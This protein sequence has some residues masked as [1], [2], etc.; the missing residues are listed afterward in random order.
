MDLGRDLKTARDRL[1]QLHTDNNVTKDQL[2][3]AKR[4][5]AHAKGRLIKFQR[6]TPLRKTAFPRWRT[7]FAMPGLR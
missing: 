3:E 5:L 7:E 6:E 1:K 4:D 2:I